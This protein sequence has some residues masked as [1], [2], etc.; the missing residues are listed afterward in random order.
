MASEPVH[1]GAVGLSPLLGEEGGES[2]VGRGCYVT[3]PPVAD[4][5]ISEKEECSISKILCS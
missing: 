4:I 1:S 2:F 3:K 5:T